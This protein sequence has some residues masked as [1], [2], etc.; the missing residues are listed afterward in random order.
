MPYPSHLRRGAVGGKAISQT[1]FTV[2]LIG[3]PDA[4]G[5]REGS[6]GGKAGCCVGRWLGDGAA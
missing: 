3:A 2:L 6:K 4:V 1:V 5:P